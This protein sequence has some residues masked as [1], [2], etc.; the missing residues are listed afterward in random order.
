[1]KAG[2]FLIAATI[3]FNLSTVKVNTYD[4]FFFKHEPPARAAVQSIIQNDPLQPKGAALQNLTPAAS[5]QT[6][7]AEKINMAQI[8]LNA[9]Q[10]A[11]LSKLPLPHEAPVEKDRQ[12]EWAGQIAL[13]MSCLAF[14]MQL[15]RNWRME[16]AGKK[17]EDI[18]LRAWVTSFFV[19]AGWAAYGAGTRL[20]TVVASNC[21]ALV[22]RGY[23]IYQILKGH[24][25]SI[26]AAYGMAGVEA[27]R[28][29][30]KIIDKSGLANAWL[31]AAVGDPLN[32]LALAAT[33]PPYLQFMKTMKDLKTEGISLGS[34]ALYTL[35]SVFWG[36]NGFLFEKWA[37]VASSMAGL[38]LYG[39]VA[40]AKY[41]QIR[42]A[43]GS[44]ARM[45]AGEIAD[46]FKFA[47]EKAGK[48]WR[49]I[50]AARAEKRMEPN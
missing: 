39:S 6:R 29:G 22:P 5:T 18:S 10:A 13:L 19:D 26:Q 7:Q 4:P 47:W 50:W 14:G 32:T 25:S 41:S 45:L 43:G 37:I 23:G 2:R 30:Y 46:T 20:Y 9:A 42:A 33:M 8:P 49:L 16:K 1:M 31:Y 11:G 48:V 28:V 3:A 40:G 44:V 27:A 34:Q 38:L 17:Q 15:G 12:S 36:L 35:A 24:A 21:L